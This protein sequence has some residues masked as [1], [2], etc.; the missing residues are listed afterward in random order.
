[1]REIKFRAY[2]KKHKKMY[3]VSCLHF[4]QEEGNWCTAQYHHPIEDKT[5]RMQV[6]PKDVE[7]MQYTGLKDKNS[8]EI[9]EGDIIVWYV[10]NLRRAAPVVYDAGAFW[11]GKDI[12][13]GFLVC[14]D[15]LCGE[16][17]IMGNIHENTELLNTG[18]SCAEK[19]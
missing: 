18:T 14:N 7:I 11:M 15:W 6:Q 12:K 17:E 3:S 9:Y 1:M 8:K 4:N 10:N 19:Q 5:V 2:S 16:Y 13:T